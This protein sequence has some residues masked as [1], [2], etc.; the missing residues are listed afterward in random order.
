MPVEL[1]D[2][3][4][5][6]RSRDWSNLAEADP[7]GTFFHTPAYLKLWWEEFATGSLLL[8]FVVED[9]ET[10]AACAFEVVDRSL[11][12][13]GGFDVTDYM[14]PVALPRTEERAAKEIMA[15]L[16]ADGSWDR[17]D[18]RGMPLDSPWHGALDSAAASQGLSVEPGDDGVAPAIS[19]PQTFDAYLARLPPKLRHEIRR[20]ERRLV[21]EAGPYRIE[22]ATE[23]SL[24]ADFERFIELHRSSPGP[25]GKFL[26]AGM[27]IFFRRLGEAFL[28]PHVFHLAFLEIDGQQVAGAIGFAYKNTFS[29]YNSA[30]DRE[31]AHLSPGMVLVAELIRRAIE[32]G[33]ETFDLLKGDL[34]YKYRFGPTPRPL[35]RLVLNR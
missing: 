4:T 14:G 35:G 33:R 12:F 13:L 22:V 11:R 3:P 10:V 23:R 1:I 34:E 30:F 16:A 31:F 2:D 29:L 15:A 20:K 17:A 28:P 7:C 18:L 6:F 9:A 25:K 8:A 27:E 26:H 24:A 5:A 19:L 21:Q 32:L